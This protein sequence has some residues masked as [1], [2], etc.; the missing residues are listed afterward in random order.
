MAFGGGGVE[1]GAASDPCRGGERGP[2]GQ[3]SALGTEGDGLRIPHIGMPAGRRAN[4]P[5]Q[6]GASGLGRVSGPSSLSEPPGRAAQQFHSRI[7]EPGWLARRMR[8]ATGMAQLHADDDGSGF[9][10]FERGVHGQS[11]PVGAPPG[12]DPPQPKQ[13]E[14]SSSVL[15]GR[16]AVLPVIEPLPEMLACWFGPRGR[17]AEATAFWQALPARMAPQTHRARP[18]NCACRGEGD[19]VQSTSE[20]DSI[21]VEGA[22][23]TSSIRVSQ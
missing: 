16:A 11:Y 6:F 17:R 8:Q 20:P 15:Q 23:E 18:L 1:G 3:R 12:E 13:R 10:A 7:Q 4:L 5:P 22:W 19:A 21:P 2:C 9:V 14:M